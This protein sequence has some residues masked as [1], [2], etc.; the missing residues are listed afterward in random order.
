MAFRIF[1]LVSCLVVSS[2]SAPAGQAHVFTQSIVQ[3][4]TS[5]SS[6]LLLVTPQ[7]KETYKIQPQYVQPLSTLQFPREQLVYYYPPSYTVGGPH[8]S[9]IPLREEEEEVPWWQQF[10]NQITGGEE[11]KLTLFYYVKIVQPIDYI[12]F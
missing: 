10:W 12:N 1:A 5:H 6:Q 3:T 11:C 8:L 4:P 7:L 9:L 2:Y